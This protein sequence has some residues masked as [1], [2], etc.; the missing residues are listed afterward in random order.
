V[1][2]KPT[3]DDFS[4]NIDAPPLPYEIFNQQDDEKLKEGSLYFSRKPRNIDYKPYTIEQYKQIKPKEYVELGKLKPG[5]IF[6]S[7][8]CMKALQELII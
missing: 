1:K 2:I 3:S 5:M 6:T 4:C 7:I 8:H